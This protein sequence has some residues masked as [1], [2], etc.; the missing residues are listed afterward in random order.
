MRFAIA[1]MAAAL[2]SVVVLR[3]ADAKTVV[4]IPP[5]VGPDFASLRF[6]SSTPTRYATAYQKALQYVQASVTASGEVL[7][8]P[9]N[10]A[11]EAVSGEI[12]SAL[13][14]N[15]DPGPAARIASWLR[16]HQ[17]P[18]GG[19]GIHPKMA[20]DLTNTAYALYGLEQAAYTSNPPAWHTYR[21]AITQASRFLATL[22]TASGGLRESQASPVVPALGN[23]VAARALLAAGTIGRQLGWADASQDLATGYRVAHALNVDNAISRTTTSD[24]LAA[25]LMDLAPSRVGGQRQVASLL[26]LGFAYPGFGAKVGPGYLSGMDWV[27]A[28][29]TFNLVIAAANVGLGAIAVSQYNAGLM[30]QN[31]DGGFGVVS[32][33]SVGPETGAYSRGPGPSRAGVTAQFLL[34]TDV[35]LKDH[36]L[37]TAGTTVTWRNASG[38][39]VVAAKPF[40]LIDPVIPMNPPTSSR[41]AVLVPSTLSPVDEKAITSATPERN[42]QLQAAYELT[43]LG[44]AVDLFWVKPNQAGVYYPLKDLWPNLSQFQLLVLPAGSMSAHSG[45]IQPLKARSAQI[46]RWVRR[47]GRLLE[48][49][50]TSAGV[51]GTFQGFA[52]KVARHAMTMIKIASAAVGRGSLAWLSA[53]RAWSQQPSLFQGL[54][55]H[56]QVL[57]RAKIARS[58]LPVIEGVKDG[59]GRVLATTLDIASPEHDEWSL[60][61]ALVAWVDAGANQAAPLTPPLQTAGAKLLSTLRDRYYVP[62][63]R[64]FRETDRPS[65]RVSFLWPLTQTLAGVLSFER[66]DVR[67]KTWLPHLFAGL[68]AYFNSQLHPPAYLPYLASQGGTAPYYDDNGWVGLDLMAGYQATGSVSDLHR[69]EAVFRFLASGWNRRARP[70]GGEYFDIA[71]HVR[72]QTATGSF[73]NLALR[74]YLATKNRDYLKWAHVIQTWDASYF[75]GPNGIYWDSMSAKGK[76]KGLP[77]PSD[78]GIMLQAAVLWYRVDKSPAALAAAENLA[79]SALTVFVNPLNQEITDDAVGSSAAFNM[80]L[81][82]GLAML[83]HF[84][85]NPVYRSIILDQAITAYHD[86]QVA[87]GLYGDNWNG[88]NNPARALDVL[89][90]GATLNLFAVAAKLDAPA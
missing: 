51:P 72:T 53:P 70:V 64:L 2:I 52:P 47:G 60:L 65:H 3:A 19:F 26:T 14:L 81:V 22:A 20:S 5:N 23:A 16:T 1:S 8:S 84:D 90:E 44:F 46:R 11:T 86:D 55:A 32:H 28:S 85:P 30:M 7:N 24:F 50:E 33:P 87:G 13:A 37:G 62:E 42:L 77:L 59:K 6:E 40:G 34:A 12:L 45:F 67:A 43:R 88:L 49:G 21:S 36:L 63:S 76:V 10:P 78:T 29:A 15:Q 17:N 58:W 89:T 18:D 54:A 68:S 57:G 80:M 38:A 83:Y 9:G 75:A 73:L 4:S 31:P 82:Q 71:H 61:A 66:I 74:L 41:V 69:A 35:L 79:D 56:V 27:D 48:L 39:T 25:P